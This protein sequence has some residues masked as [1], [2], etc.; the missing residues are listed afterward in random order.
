MAKKKPWL[1]GI[2]NFIFPGAGYIYNGKR[3]VFAIL[4]IAGIIISIIGDFYYNYDI[5]VM[6]TFY[7]WVTG[8]LVL[9]G[10]GYD[11][12]QEA[13]ELNKRKK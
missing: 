12:Y 7:Q 6:T 2:L 4:L 10:F 5:D 8:L 13:K 3:K 1:A 9:F 11:A